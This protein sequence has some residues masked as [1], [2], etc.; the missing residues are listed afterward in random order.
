VVKLSRLLVGV[1]GALALGGQA[2][3]AETLAPTLIVLD[4]SIGGVS[5]REGRAAVERDLGRGVALSTSIDRSARPEPA[6]IQRVAYLSGAL[7]V[8][9]VSMGVQQPQVALLESSSPRYRTRSGVGVGSTYAQL[10][11]IGGVHCYAPSETECQHGY[12]STN[13][14]GT[15]FRLDRPGGRIAYIAITFGH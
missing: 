7:T 6:H 5:L 2:T 9:Y 11:T 14:P 8:T 13:K 1:C 3:A 10:H 4:H 15:T 12:S